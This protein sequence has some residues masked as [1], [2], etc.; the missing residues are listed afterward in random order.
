[1][2]LARLKSPEA[3]EAPPMP[4]L[5]EDIALSPGPRRADGSPSWVLHDPA[6]N[7]YFDIGWREFEVLS[8]WQ[9]GPPEA[10]ATAV[11]QQ[12]TLTV[13]PDQVAQVANFLTSNGLLRHSGAK[14][15]ALREK[16]KKLGVMASASQLTGNLLFRKIPLL[17]PDPFLRR[18]AGLVRPLFGA[19]V[20]WLVGALLLLALYLVGRQWGQFI[21]GFDHLYSLEGAIGV[22]LALTVAKSVHELSHAYVARLNGV[23]V[24]SMGVSLILLWPVLYTETSAAWRI[25]DRSKRLRIAVAGVASE[26]VLAVLALLAW[27]FLDAG[28][29]RDTMQFAASSLVV[30][31]LAINANPLMRFD[32]YFV[33][34]DLTGMENLQPRS[35]ALLGWAFRR[36][37]AGTPEP[38]PEPGL[39]PRT[40]AAVMTFGAALGLYRISLY[41]GI[42]YGLT[43]MVFPA[44]G[45]VLAALVVVCFLAWPAS[46]ESVR[47]FRIAAKRLGP[48]FG[49]LRVGAVL[50]LLALPLVV[51]WRTSLMLPV[52]LRLGEAHAVFT[53]EPGVVARL[54]VADGQH[55]TLGQ[56]LIEMASPDLAHK[57]EADRL[58]AGRLA[59]LL[60]QHMTQSD[61]REDEHVEEE[62]ILRLRV[63]ITGLEARLAKLTL[64]AASDG[65][66]RDV[67]PGLKPGAWVRDDRPLMRVVAGGAVSAQAYVEERDLYLV[68]AG[69]EGTMW[70]DGNP[71]GRIPVRVRSLY[72][73]AIARIEAPIIAGPGGG[74]I[75]VKQSADK[76]WVPETAIYKA[77]LDLTGAPPSLGG[78]SMETRGFANIDTPPRNIIG[79]I[80]DRIVGVWRREIG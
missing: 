55:V 1:M 15:L 33:L 61:Y 31:S 8:R 17:S 9:L 32:G 78:Q 13:G 14:I 18:T 72:G 48:V 12:T 24:P 6:A 36:L 46:R 76:T 23:E 42:A 52:V 68:A 70:L 5:R 3:A 41:S 25:P 58:K 21:A 39:S 19:G 43:A 45:M 77:E 50:A 34:C 16:S 20:L 73:Q 53:P 80:W 7:V 44:L 56:A 66:V 37:M 4:P 51:P 29:L 10:I 67:E 69:A 2:A 27:P 26:L 22:A 54:L 11:S 47:W 30:L 59:V 28:W 63:E 79:R 65:T 74:P 62:E 57:L 75:Q 38:S 35:L 40:H 60:D 71:F 64:R 49:A